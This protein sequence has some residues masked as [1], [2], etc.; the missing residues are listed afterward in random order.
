MVHATPNGLRKRSPSTCI[1]TG[2]CI[3]CTC[4][5]YTYMEG[6]QETSQAGLRC[7][8]GSWFLV[9]GS[10]TPAC[11]T[12]KAILFRGSSLPRLRS[13]YGERFRV[14]TTS[15]C[16]VRKR[17]FTWSELTRDKHGSRLKFALG[18][19]RFIA[20]SSR[21]YP[22]SLTIGVH[23]EPLATGAVMCQPWNYRRAEK[24]EDKPR[25]H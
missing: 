6:S 2:W 12:L 21:G 23:R 1:S 16:V 25:N 15:L 14:T 24:T 11:K 18:R 7:L 17:K 22:A 9:P 8:V 19:Y 5:R 4:T 3:T 20:L 13:S 10:C